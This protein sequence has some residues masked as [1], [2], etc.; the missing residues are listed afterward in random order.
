MAKKVNNNEN[1][2][3][4]NSYINVD[5]IDGSL[6]VIVSVKTYKYCDKC[7][8]ELPGGS[9]EPFCDFYCYQEFCAENARE[10]DSVWREIV[11]RD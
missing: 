2:N 10:I 1:N 9:L 3:S 4:K 7:G 6:K 11:Q 5:N 8:K